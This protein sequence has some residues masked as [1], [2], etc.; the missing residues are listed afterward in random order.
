MIASEK[1]LPDA[2]IEKR[3][4]GSG[5]EYKTWQTRVVA[6]SDWHTQRQQNLSGV[7]AQIKLDKPLSV[8]P[9]ITHIRFSPDGRYILAQSPDRIYVLSRDPFRYLFE[10][11]DLQNTANW[12]DAQFTPD[13]QSL[14]FLTANLRVESWDIAS[15]RQTQVREV[16]VSKGCT[17]SLLSG[18]GK[19]LACLTAEDNRLLLLDVASGMTRFEKKLVWGVPHSWRYGAAFSPDM[20]YFLLVTYRAGG[21]LIDIQRGAEISVS[22][23][24]LDGI[25]GGFTFLGADR[26]AGINSV[27]LQADLLTFPSGKIQSK[28]PISPFDG[29]LRA[30][31]HG[32]YVIF[33]DRRGNQPSVAMDTTTRK[34][35]VLSTQ[36]ALDIYDDAFVMQAPDGTMGLYDAN[37][38]ARRSQIT[39][40]GSALDPTMVVV[41]PDLAWLALS[42]QEHGAI[43]QVSTG[44]QV[45][46]LHEFRGGWFS[47]DGWFYA[48]FPKIEN[49]VHEVVRVSLSGK[50]SEGSP[51][52]DAYV[53][54]AGRFLVVNKP[55]RPG[56]PSAQSDA[57]MQ[58][59]D[60]ANALAGLIWAGNSCSP[61]AQAFDPLGCDVTL[62]V[63][64]VNTGNVLW[65]RQF[66]KN[67]PQFAWLTE[68][69][70]VLLKWSAS[71]PGARDEIHK[72]PELEA[73]FKAGGDQTGTQL[74][75]VLNMATG[76]VLKARLVDADLVPWDLIG[77]P[78]IKQSF[79]FSRGTGT[80]IQ[81][82]SQNE[83]EVEI[84]GSPL[85]VSPDRSL[86]ATQSD[87]GQVSVYDLGSLEKVEDLTFADSVLK[88]QFSQDA[89]KLFVL[90]DSQTAY[91]LA[92]NPLR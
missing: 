66:P 25:S 3:S 90:T 87:T 73:Q 31:G 59:E 64:E 22:D 65:S 14:V 79:V 54:Q 69:N 56:L 47:S 7:L 70:K 9:P 26:I 17:Q 24:L 80:V 89:K 1:Q 39:L 16:V 44:K 48:D 21:V 57:L 91:L 38:V 23:A 32:D 5:D 52:Q 68:D 71:T 2:C 50:Q 19:T 36:R 8:G 37:P 78:A 35:V 43:W 18:D 4:G 61:I 81:S 15:Q 41:S 28:L 60:V 11:D 10:I 45:S 51:L 72:Y 85:A 13:S 42:K 58:N 27:T 76:D 74:L 63:R 40:P 67:V 83:E 53:Q 33:S 75:E 92:I 20:R 82:G 88:V 29:P 77:D 12:Q 55:K 30:A 49:Q 62:E 34:I 86:L 46:D 84:P 6:F